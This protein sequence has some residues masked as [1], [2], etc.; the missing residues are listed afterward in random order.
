[1]E[2]EGV[3]FGERSQIVIDPSEERIKTELK[4]VRRFFVP[5]HAVLRID[6]VERQG[7]A[8]IRAS[9]GKGSVVAPFPVPIVPKPDQG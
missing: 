6:Q 1:M 9:S 4:D 2:I 5:L 3:T 8:R 7:S